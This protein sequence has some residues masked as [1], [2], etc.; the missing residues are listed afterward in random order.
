MAQEMSD[1]VSWAFFFFIWLPPHCF[2]LIS[3]RLL[4]PSSP[5]AIVPF[6]LVAHCLCLAEYVHGVA[7]HGSLPAVDGAWWGVALAAIDGVGKAI[8]PLSLTMCLLPVLM[9]PVPPHHC[10]PCRHLSCPRVH[11]V[12]NHQAPHK[13][14]GLMAVVGVLVSRRHRK[15]VSNQKKKKKGKK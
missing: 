14:E 4:V 8:P 10:H 7:T 6:G 11:L 9:L 2:P 15:N 13:Q 1:D 5:T 12:D 3:S